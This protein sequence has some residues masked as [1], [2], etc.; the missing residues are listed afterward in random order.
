M[1]KVFFCLLPVLAQAQSSFKSDQKTTATQVQN[2]KFIIAENNNKGNLF[3]DGPIIVGYDGSSLQN[4]FKIVEFQVGF[5]SKESGVYHQILCK[6][7]K[8]A[9]KVLDLIKNAKKGDKIFIE[10][11]TVE[12]PDG[13]KRKMTSVVYL[14]Q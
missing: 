3:K 4:L 5:L 6:G 12:G 14:F 11:I 2:P 8:Y 1:K 10:D 13:T 7:D 9:D